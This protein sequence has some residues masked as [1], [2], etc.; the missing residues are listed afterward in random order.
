MG[1]NFGRDTVERLESAGAAER[2]PLTRAA[3]TLDDC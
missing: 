2:R 3:A 1:R